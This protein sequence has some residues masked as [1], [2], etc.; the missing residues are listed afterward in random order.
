ME[1]EKLEVNIRKN[2]EEMTKYEECA[3]FLLGFR[4][5]MIVG[6]ALSNSIKTMERRMPEMWREPSNIKD[7]KYV[8]NNFGLAK[9]MDIDHKDTKYFVKK[10]GE[11]VAEYDD[12]IHNSIVACEVAKFMHSVDTRNYYVAS[13]EVTFSP[14]LID[15]GSKEP[16]EIV[17]WSSDS[18]SLEDEFDFEG[19]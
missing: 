7:M 13:V 12:A 8:L 4:G 17:M 3:K 14:V 1:E 11:I 9:V 6:Q 15:G 5:Q 18:V 16:T 19:A 10:N 2:E